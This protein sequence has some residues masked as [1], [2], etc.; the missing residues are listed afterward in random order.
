MAIVE[1][2]IHKEWAKPHIT[3]LVTSPLIPFPGTLRL[4]KRTHGPHL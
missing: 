4:A 2:S 3:D 1:K